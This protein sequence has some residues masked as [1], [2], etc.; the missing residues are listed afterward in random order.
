MNSLLFFSL[1][2]GS[3]IGCLVPGPYLLL[4][5]DPIEVDSRGPALKLGYLSPH[6]PR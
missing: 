6:S 2:H 3:L 1:R 4:S 5:D